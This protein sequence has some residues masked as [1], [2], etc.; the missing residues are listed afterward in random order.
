MCGDGGLCNLVPEA[1][2]EVAAGIYRSG[3][4]GSVLEGGKM[5]DIA[6][7]GDHGEALL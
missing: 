1:S 3:A 7:D 4:S 5:E 6:A 2:E